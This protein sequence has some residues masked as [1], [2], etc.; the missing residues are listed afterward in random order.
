MNKILFFGVLILT[1]AY[2]LDPRV[3]ESD[4]NYQ[5]RPSGIAG[6]GLFAAR[7]IHINELISEY[8]GVILTFNQAMKIKN[9]DYL[10][11]GIGINYHI[12]AKNSWHCW[13]RYINDNLDQEK[14]NSILIK[15]KKL[16]RVS[17]YSTKEIKQG[18]E[19]FVSY[20][21]VYWESR[22]KL[23]LTNKNILKESELNVNFCNLMENKFENNFRK[24]FYDNENYQKFLTLKIK[25]IIPLSQTILWGFIK[26][27]S[28][29]PDFSKTFCLD[30]DL[31]NCYKLGY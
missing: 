10:M 8:N 3:P 9:R 22:N 2:E 11:G 23:G 14:I 4:G 30:E 6:L 27:L 12:D 31:L 17:V 1:R 29:H 16:Q 26:E 19:I 18:D 21:N 28:K 25:Q 5:V 20:G 7:N 24:Y 13:G 15:N